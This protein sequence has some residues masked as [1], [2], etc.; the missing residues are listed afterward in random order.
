VFKGRLS[1]APFSSPQTT[2]D[3]PLCPKFAD[4]FFCTLPPK[5]CPV[6]GSSRPYFLARW[7]PLLLFQPPK[8][9]TLYGFPPIICPPLSRART[10]TSAPPKSFLL[11]T[12]AFPLV[13]PRHAALARIS[14]RRSVILLRGGSPSFYHPLS[15]DRLYDLSPRRRRLAVF[16]CSIAY[17]ASIYL[18]PFGVGP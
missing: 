3:P 13:L 10:F 11:G 2:P 4:F 14:S 12:L 8:P 15:L 16:P 9:A 7:I 17:P 1:V 5:G 6:L 18:P